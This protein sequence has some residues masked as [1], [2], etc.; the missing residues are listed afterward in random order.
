ML[1][2]RRGCGVGVRPCG[3]EWCICTATNTTSEST[4]RRRHC[5]ATFAKGLEIDLFFPSLF[6]LTLR[7]SVGTGRL[8]LQMVRSCDRDDLTP[9]VIGGATFR[10]RVALPSDWEFYSPR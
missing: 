9:S 7:L 2:R 8:S 5:T 10:G 1:V 4:N 6:Y 3:L